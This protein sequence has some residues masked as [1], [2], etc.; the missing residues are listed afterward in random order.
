MEKEKDCGFPSAIEFLGELDSAIEI[1]GRGGQIINS[2]ITRICKVCGFGKYQMMI[3]ENSAPSSIRN[4]GFNPVAG[5]KWRVYRCINC[6]HLQIFE[7][8]GNPR[9]WGEK[10]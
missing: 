10:F 7:L 5:L 9:A 2:E 8:K 1:M 3:S 6:G 4:M